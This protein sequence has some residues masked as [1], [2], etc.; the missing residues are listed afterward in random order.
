MKIITTI[1]QRDFLPNTDITRR[2]TYA[3][4]H[5]AR[6]VVTDGNGAIALLHA[7]ERDYYKLPGGGIEENE[8]ILVA[9]AREIKEE[10]GCEAEVENE[11]GQVI[12]WRDETMLQQISYA[13]LAR[14][15]GL[16]GTPDFTE[17]EIAEGFEV[18]WAPSLQD[19]LQLV[20]STNDQ[21][22]LLVRFMT[23]RDAM[24]LDV[25]RKSSL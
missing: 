21:S 13:Y 20:E 23:R 3:T 4:R 24:I 6:A 22:D 10:L 25:V 16:K 2:D 19:A 17:S 7:R 5:A 1:D 8:D 12:E 11:L 14:L 15:K 9:L 18:V